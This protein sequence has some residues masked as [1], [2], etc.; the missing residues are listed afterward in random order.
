MMACTKTEAERASTVQG[1]A[2]LHWKF[3]PPF[4]HGAKPEFTR[5]KLG[6]FANV[7]HEPSRPSTQEGMRAC[8]RWGPL[9]T[10]TP[11][12]QRIQVLEANIA[13]MQKALEDAEGAHRE[14][15]EVFIQEGR[16]ALKRLKR[17]VWH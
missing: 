15:L 5:L 8:I 6:R 1:Y 2:N 16:Q 14:L 13:R 12:T 3:A 4:G 10:A 17:H 9:L 11:D 7:P